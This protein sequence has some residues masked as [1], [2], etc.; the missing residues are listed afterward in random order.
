WAGKRLPTAEEWEVA[1]RGPDKREFPWDGGCQEKEDLFFA[2]SLE[3]WQFHKNQPPGTTPVDHKEF[4]SGVSPFGAYGMVGNVWQWTSTAAPVPA[5]ST[6][7][8]AEFRVLKGG[9]FMT[10]Q[11]A[12]RCANVYAEDPRLPLRPRCEMMRISG[13]PKGRAGRPI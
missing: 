7:P 1:A 3:Y 11:R 12:L 6:R 5:T 9:S 10:P 2:N 8:P 4:D 13:S